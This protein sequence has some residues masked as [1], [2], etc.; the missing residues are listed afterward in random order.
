MINPL[1]DNFSVI[2]D[3]RINCLR[4]LESL[5]RFQCLYCKWIAGKMAVDNKL[6]KKPRIA[7]AKSSTISFTLTVPN[8]GK[9]I[10]FILFLSDSLL[11]QKD[12]VKV[13]YER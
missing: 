5:W 13:L 1:I 12:L 9:I 6:I 7:P 11:K 4:P 10:S 2:N 3:E 8:K